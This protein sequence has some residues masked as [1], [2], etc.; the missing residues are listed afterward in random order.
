MDLSATIIF[1]LHGRRNPATPRILGRGML[2]LYAAY[3]FSTGR[4]ISVEP[5]YGVRVAYAF[6]DFSDP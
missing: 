4:G 1:H 5:I 3:E 2:G 6:V